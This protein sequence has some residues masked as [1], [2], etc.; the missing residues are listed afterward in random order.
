MTPTPPL[1]CTA[2]VGEE[3]IR[4]LALLPDRQ[5]NFPL[6]PDDRYTEADGWHV[7]DVA[8]ELPPE[9]PGEPLEHGSF[10]VARRVL[11]RY[12]FADQRLVRAVFVD[13]QP[14]DGRDMLLV[15]RFFGLRF[16]MGV[17]VGGVTDDETV[18]EGRRVRRFGWHYRTLEG[19]LERGQM[20]Y[21]LLKWLD[22]G[23]VELR[24]H[25]VSQRAHIDNPIVRLGFALFGR[26]T[27]LRFYDR[28][29]R[30]TFE[31]VAARYRPD[32]DAPA[33]RS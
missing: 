10:S 4:Q 12:E 5:I 15:G 19:H 27:Q 25:A 8:C 20:D 29:L 33:P 23:S 30:R 16:R 11:E 6:R 2:P 22:T 24:I 21:E 1:Y 14:L 32:G 18:L 31:L 28:A 9:P 13:D 3:A 26:R 17:R 7:D